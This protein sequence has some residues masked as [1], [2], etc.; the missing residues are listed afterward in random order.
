[1][2]SAP[3]FIRGRSLHRYGA[4]HALAANVAV[5]LAMIGHTAGCIEG[6]FEGLAGA[7]HLDLRGLR[8]GAD[9]GHGGDDEGLHHHLTIHLHRGIWAWE[10]VSALLAGVRMQHGI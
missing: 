10:F 4:G 6:V 8:L 2:R 3:I 5:E 9:L 1:M 7:N